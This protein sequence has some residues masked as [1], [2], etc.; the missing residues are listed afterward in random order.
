MSQNNYKK[1]SQSYNYTKKKPINQKSIRKDVPN[2]INKIK[3]NNIFF[4]KINININKPKNALNW[5]NNIPS[6]NKI[7]K[8]GTELHSNINYHYQNKVGNKF[9]GNSQFKQ[10]FG[11][12]KPQTNIIN[13]NNVMNMKKELNVIQI[14]NKNQLNNEKKEDII[15]SINKYRL[16]SD[17]PDLSFDRIQ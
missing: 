8:P 16:P 9:I 15:N 11:K 14:Q 6:N 10:P 2:N 13:N 7:G 12:P 3:E 17:L 5:E 4:H 1:K